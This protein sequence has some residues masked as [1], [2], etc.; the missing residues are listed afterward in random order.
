MEKRTPTWAEYDEVQKA[1][2]LLCYHCRIEQNRPDPCTDCAV[3]QVLKGVF[4]S[5]PEEE[6]V[7]LIIGTNPQVLSQ[8]QR[9]VF[10]HT[11]WA[12][13]NL[14]TAA[15]YYEGC[16]IGFDVRLVKSR[17]GDY[18]SHPV[19][20]GYGWGRTEVN[21][22]EGAIWYSFSGE[23]LKEHMLSIREEFPDLSQFEE[24]D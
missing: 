10:N 17:N 15:H 21:Y 6:T 5:L 14:Q 3:N 1:R 24:D 13:D 8:M 12:S 20:D 4:Q 18:C 22:P 9:G 2:N 16:V 7:H 19:C 23:Y 11:I